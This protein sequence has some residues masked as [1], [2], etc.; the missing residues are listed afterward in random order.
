M[1]TVTGKESHSSAKAS[2]S[3]ANNN[4]QGKK[5]AHSHTDRLGRE[6]IELLK[7]AVTE[8]QKARG[9]NII[10]LIGNTGTGKSTA[11]NH[12]LGVK[13]KVVRAA[14]GCVIQAAQ[15]GE[16]IARIGHRVG[17]SETR[18]AYVYEKAGSPLTFADC[19]GFFDTRGVSTDI[20]VV[21]SLKLTLEN[22]QSVKLVLC[23]DST[24][25]KTDRAIHFSQAVHLVLGTLL[26]NYK[27]H[28]DSVLIL[29]TKPTK[30]LDNTV[31]DA[32]EAR[33][34]LTEIMEDL[35]EGTQ[36]ELYKFLL[37]D[38]GKYICV[39]D[40]LSDTSRETNQQ[41]L[42]AMG[43]ID[44]PKN[45]FQTAYTA[46]SQL[47]L[48][49][50]MTAIAVLG[51]DLYGDYFLN[52]EA[53]QRYEEEISQLNNKL[54]SINESIQTMGNGQS[55]PEAIKSAEEKIIAENKTLILQQN[56]KLKEFEEKIAENNCNIDAIQEKIGLHDRRG[57]EVI[58]Y[59]C[60]TINQEG[61]NIESRT[62]TVTTNEKSNWY[63]GGSSSQ[64]ES[65]TSTYDKRSIPRDFYYRGPEIARIVKEPEQGSCWSKEDKTPISYSI[66]YESGKGE[67]A[68]ATLKVFVKRK[69]M[70]T[71]LGE[72]AVLEQQVSRE[73][74]VI[75]QY[76]LEIGET[77]KVINGAEMIV[78]AKGNLLEKIQ[79]YQE[80]AAELDKAIKERQKQ[81]E[82]YRAANSAVEMEIG[83]NSADFIFLKN[84]IE[85][86]GDT[87][88][89]NNEVVAR[90]LK[91]D[92]I[93]GD[94]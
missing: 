9:K 2:F 84:Y 44:N 37:R 65:T 93:Y 49:E 27:E 25:I 50:E 26:K 67:A 64:T 21:T 94:R 66:H 79:H 11:V 71:E 56:D 76:L 43:K 82:V 29:F 32:A 73:K 51:G 24:I 14:R 92:L 18:Y 28:Q 6:V 34:A 45:A 57:E 90:F 1:S 4:T 5:A 72:K 48:L 53:I 17:T 33:Q 19:G 40:P 86:S 47:K 87:N 89:K 59:W 62:V 63:G 83:S 91:Q 55:S 23:F 88:L 20:A 77:Q 78:A 8:A 70:P 15:D 7:G 13:L 81:V 58:E 16:E 12:L 75:N 39:C 80:A 3:N 46:H 36:K 35:L 61:I 10:A 52:K 60:D 69:D 31:F 68:I 38:G 41:I 74:T 54:L 22:A 30:N 42:T 85:L